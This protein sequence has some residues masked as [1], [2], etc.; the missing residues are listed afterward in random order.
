MFYGELALRGPSPAIA[1]Y[2]FAR[3]KPQIEVSILRR[4]RMHGAG[5]DGARGLPGIAKK[6][7]EET[8]DEGKLL[9]QAADNSSPDVQPSCK[10]KLQ[11]I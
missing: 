3:N 5:D 4:T 9:A 7:T 1:R 10:R 8:I 6:T 2:L 11:W